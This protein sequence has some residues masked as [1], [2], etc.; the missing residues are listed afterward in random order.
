MKPTATSIAD[1]VVSDADI[2]RNDVRRKLLS[3]HIIL[4]FD[5]FTKQTYVAIKV[6]DEHGQHSDDLQH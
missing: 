5:R 4:G 2:V 6:Q 1:I 3:L